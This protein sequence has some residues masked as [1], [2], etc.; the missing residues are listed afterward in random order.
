MENYTTE[1][2]TEALRAINSVIHKCEKALKK[3]PEGNSHHTLLRNRLKAM[4]ISKMLITE[5]LSK[6]ELSTEPRTLS[7]DSCDS[8]LLLSNLS[9]LHTTDLGIERI[10][11]NLR[12]NTNDVVG[13]C[14]SKIKAPNAS[15]SRKGK[16]W[17]ITVD[18][19]EFTV[20]AHSYTIITAHKRT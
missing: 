3:F 14:R 20:N 7:D 10:R 9:Q 17:Y 15:I 11:K 19:C 13:W 12:L 2:L 6:M 1:E 18:S 16:N 8:E 4:Y 5:A